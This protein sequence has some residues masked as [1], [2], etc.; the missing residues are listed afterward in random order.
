MDG[1]SKR[2]ITNGLQNANLRDLYERMMT[3]RKIYCDH[4]GKEVNR[5][6]DYTNFTIDMS[7]AGFTNI[8]LCADCFKELKRLIDKFCEKRNGDA[9]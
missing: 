6:A 8:D 7:H 2:R 1:A 5:M 9:E 3:M 4:C